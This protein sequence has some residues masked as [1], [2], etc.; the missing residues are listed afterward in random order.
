[1]LALGSGLEDFKASVH[2][3]GIV[4]RQ[5]ADELILAWLKHQRQGLSRALWEFTN[6]VDYFKSFSNRATQARREAN[7]KKIQDLS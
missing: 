4:T 3:R 2:P 1:M 5:I 7:L 6:F